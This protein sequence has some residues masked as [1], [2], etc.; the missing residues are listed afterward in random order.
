MND[1]PKSTKVLLGIVL[2]MFV[3]LLVT[4]LGNREGVTDN[5]SRED[6]V[7][8]GVKNPDKVLT[9]YKSKLKK[10]K[11]GADEYLNAIVKKDRYT[12]SKEETE[13]FGDI[14]LNSPITVDK[15]TETKLFITYD[16]TEKTS[17]DD[18]LKIKEYLSKDTAFPTQIIYKTSE[19]SFE[20][21]KFAYVDFLYQ[22]ELE[23]KGDNAEFLG[24]DKFSL[25]KAYLVI[26]GKLVK[27]Y[28]DLS[29]LELQ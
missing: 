24:Y 3:M 2:T 14:I 27:E 11:S 10:D 25:P 26:D 13:I 22:N 12:L 21:G 7:A 19:N 23:E 17:S 8:V 16:K 5:V 15:Y 4:W 20:I 29:K 1:V 6:L 18:L 9:E 28:D